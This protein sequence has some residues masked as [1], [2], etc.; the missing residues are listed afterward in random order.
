MARPFII[1]Y[2]SV[3]NLRTILIHSVTGITE[4]TRSVCLFVSLLINI[5]IKY[6]LKYYFQNTYSFSFLIHAHIIWIKK[7]TVT[8]NIKFLLH[9]SI[10]CNK[11]LWN[12]LGKKTKK[13]KK[14]KNN[15]FLRKEK[16]K[17]TKKNDWKRKSVWSLLKN[18]KKS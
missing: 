5:L 9:L 15:I 14:T 18:K 8:R 12:F 4:Y 7:K 17:H 10:L 1:F 3:I 11:I 16:K 6:I 13:K 2:S